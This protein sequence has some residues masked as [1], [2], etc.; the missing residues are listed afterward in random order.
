MEYKNAHKKENKKI[1]AVS[2]KKPM[3][4]RCYRPCY[5]AGNAG[6]PNVKDRG[7]VSAEKTVACS[8]R[9]NHQL[10]GSHRYPH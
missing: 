2:L 1:N 10:A 9:L 4:L 3:A 6:R 8:K 5:E 7:S